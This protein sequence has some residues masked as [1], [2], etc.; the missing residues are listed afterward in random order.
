MVTGDND[1]FAAR[2]LRVFERGVFHLGLAMIAFRYGPIRT[3]AGALIE[4]AA[5]SFAETHALFPAELRERQ[6]SID[7]LTD[8]ILQVKLIVAYD[9]I[10]AERI[11][12]EERERFV[13]VVEVV[14]R[15]FGQAAT[16][17]SRRI[18]FDETGNPQRR[19]HPLD[20]QI[21]GRRSGKLHAAERGKRN[22]LG[23]ADASMRTDKGREVDEQAGPIV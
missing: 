2:R 5:A 20:L 18:D 3:S 6:G 21:H 11:G 19:I 4:V 9:V 14:Y 10:F 16:A 1:Q 22:A 15:E 17:R 13:D 7:D 23:D 12:A 8:K